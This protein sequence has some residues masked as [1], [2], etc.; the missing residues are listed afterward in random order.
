MGCAFRRL[1]LFIGI[2]LSLFPPTRIVAAEDIN[3]IRIGAP[4]RYAEAVGSTT[5][6][7]FPDFIDTQ[8]AEGR[9]GFSIGYGSYDEATTLPYSFGLSFRFRNRFHVEDLDA[10]RWLILRMDYRDGFVAYLNG[11]EFLR[12]GLPGDPGSPVPAELSAT[13]RIR[14]GAEDIDISAHKHL[15]VRGE[16]VIAVQ[17]HGWT[18]GAIGL[19]FAPELLAN[20]NRGPFLQSTTESSIKIVWRTPIPTEGAVVFGQATTGPWETNRSPVATEHSVQL[21]GLSAGRE[22]VYRIESRDAQGT[23]ASSGLSTFRTAPASGGFRLAVFGDSGLGSQAQYRVGE[24]IEASKPDL[25]LHCGDIIYPEFTTSRAD[26]RCLSVY[27][28]HMRTTPY[29]FS[30]GNHDLYAG[31]S[32]FRDTFHLPTNS[33]FGTEDFYSFDH[34]DL[35]VAVVLA[36][37]LSQYSPTVG[38]PQHRWLEQDLASSKKPWKIIVMHHP[39]MTSSAHRFDDYNFNRIADQDDVRNYVLPLASKHGVQLVLTGHDHV[40][41]RFNPVQGVHSIVTGGGGIYL[42]GLT[43]PDEASSQLYITHHAVMITATN[44]VMRVRGFDSF[45]REFDHSIIGRGPPSEQLYASSKETVLVEAVSANDDDGNIRGQSFAFRGPGVA[46]QS[47]QTS[48]LGE[49]WVSN[50]STNLYVGLSGVM[51]YPHQE[52]YLFLQALRVNGVSTLAGLGNGKAD[53]FGEG[54][55][56]LDFLENLHFTDFAPGM[57]LIL[58]DEYADG[59]M[60]EFQRAGTLLPG[61]QGAFFLRPGLP[62]AHGVRIQ[63]FNRSPQSGLVT[64]ERNANLIKVGIPFS[65]LG[66][67]RFGDEIKIAAV[68]GSEPPEALLR[69]PA[70]V[71]D[72]GFHGRAFST[73]ALGHFELKPLTFHLEVNREDPDDD[74]LTNDQELIYDTNPNLA[75]S[76]GDGLPD[77]WEI[78][79]GLNPLVQDSAQDLDLDGMSNLSEFLAGTEPATPLSRLTLSALPLDGGIE[80][81]WKGVQGRVYALQEA[82]APG[83]P[84]FDMN[85]AGFPRVSKGTDEIVRLAVTPGSLRPTRFLRLRLV[86]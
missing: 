20:F 49:L 23:L 15:L 8:W 68:V 19:A 71:F 2:A 36:P 7:I 85:L 82:L 13:P 46:S 76:D 69:P 67:L 81:R 22:Y 1:G 24:L 79:H 53:P 65:E 60:R 3:L 41:E 28:R 80:L 86:Y 37:Y 5:N 44:Q 45:Q 62:T 10:I 84:F 73:N 4:W 47:G 25:V 29:Y 9:S 38:D 39:M 32:H 6:W 21:T 14:A 30:M 74:G 77:G 48:N 66:G 59:T 50:D 11:K 54:A 35:H 18:S 40:F 42:Y 56:A 57:A 43:S 61:G 17:V 70:R 75:D 51:I 33:V 52:I 26:L 12:R 64:Y 16:N 34:A 31:P 58:G 78:T 63:Q 83:G 27:G 55:D 72:T